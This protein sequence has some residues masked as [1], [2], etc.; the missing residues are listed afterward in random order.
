MDANVL[1]EQLDSD[2]F[3]GVPDS[4]LRT[5]V[6]ALYS[7]YGVYNDH[8]IIA[9]NEGNAVGIAAGYHLATGKIPVVYM[10]NSGE[11][12]AINPIASLLNDKVYAIPMIFVI[13]WRGQPGVH[14]EPQHIYQGEITLKLL[15][16]MGVE[17][18]VVTQ[19][20]T[21]EALIEQIE[22]FKMQLNAGKDVAFVITK[23]AL[24]NENK[25]K[26]S[27][28]YTLNREEVIENIVDVAGDDLIVST[29]GKISRELFEIRER[30]GMTHK[31]DFLTVGSMG[32]A[33]SIALGIAIQKPE[34]RV[35]CL[36]GDGAL[37]M[38]MGAIPVVGHMHP[39]NMVHVLLN[40]ASH[41]TVG[42]MPTVA[43]TVSFVDV[44]RASGYKK[45]LAT[46]NLN[47]LDRM[48]L[49]IKDSSLPFLQV[50]C[51]IGSR[52]DLGRPTTTAKE[53]KYGFMNGM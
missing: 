30:K 14:D 46:D 48:L 38:H 45:V 31:H 22:K 37:L 33:S 47:D 2:F 49:E 7:K 42:G 43:D 51:G 39:D 25:V 35:W 16:V 8:H 50:D 44:A 11:G 17:Y 41:E 12:N 34:R 18:C 1:L 36:D 13:G 10:Q 6:D 19:E 40:N 4:Q 20:T 26:Y 23:G 24:T 15:E 53:N 9:A 29:T 3:C 32:H 21:K 52:A 5:F 27:N 28:E